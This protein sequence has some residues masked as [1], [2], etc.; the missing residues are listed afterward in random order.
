MI[1]KKK[2]IILLVIAAAI[3]L[4][5]L[6]WTVWSNTALVLTEYTV[7]SP[8]LPSAF[9]GFRIAHI[10]DL[11][12]AEMGSGNGKL[13]AM[14][15]SAQPDIIAITGDL[16]DSRRTDVSV[17]LEFAEAAMNIAPCYYVTGN[18]ESRVE[19]YAQL[20]AGLLA[21]GVVVLENDSVTLERDR[22]TVTLLGVTDPEFEA[23]Y[24]LVF[25]EEVMDKY[26]AALPQTE[27]FH[28]LLSH[29]PEYMN[30]YAQ[31]GFNLVLSGHAHGGQFRLPII[32]G[33]YAP[34]QGLFPEYDAGLFSVEGTQMI[35]SRGI[36]NSAFPLR[37]NNRP[38][39]VLITLTE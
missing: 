23:D 22:Q 1:K 9:D 6:I 17:A 8:E 28:L 15:R 36:G 7:Q 35:V 5:L 29:R 25:P 26:L 39:V 10:S 14:L 4:P 19:E 20:K 31:C 38:E 30:M 16:I 27:G 18:H 21:L 34:G 32:G 3:L 12:N 2:T 24:W 11:H 13:L 33:L 37:F